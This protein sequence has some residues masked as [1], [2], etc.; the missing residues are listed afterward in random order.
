MGTAAVQCKGNVGGTPELSGAPCR[1]IR[2]CRDS[3][4]PP[5]RTP[6]VRSARMLRSSPGSA[7]DRACVLRQSTGAVLVLS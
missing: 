2:N 1:I 5:T 7:G 4:L 6:Q 3:A